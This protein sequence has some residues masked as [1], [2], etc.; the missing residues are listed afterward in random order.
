[1]KDLE[2]SQKSFA[3]LIPVGLKKEGEAVFAE[4]WQAQAFAMTISLFQDGLFTWDEWAETLGIEIAKA[5]GDDLDGARY[6][7]YWLA[8]LEAIVAKKGSVKSDQLD[9]LKEAWADAYRDTPHGKPVE[10]KR[11]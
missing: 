6:Y 9:S 7:Q 11:D 1:M 5:G 2:G 10:L 8:A 4:P 3:T